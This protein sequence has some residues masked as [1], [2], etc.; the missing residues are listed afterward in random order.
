MA[1]LGQYADFYARMKDSLIG[2]NI[3]KNLAEWMVNNTM[4]KGRKWSFFEHEF[5]LDIAGDPAQEG[6]VKKCSQIG[7]TELAVRMALA[8]LA[9]SDGRSLIYVLPTSKFAAKFSKSR[10]DP[11][12]SSS[13][14]LKELMVTAADSSDLKRIGDSFLYING[15]ADATQAISVPAEGLFT[16]ERDFCNPAVLS[17]YDSRS[18]HARDEKYQ[19]R[20]STP[21]L[22]GYGI[23]EDYSLS[24]QKRYLVKCRHCETWV[25]PDFVRDVVIPGYDNDFMTFDKQDVT[26]AEFHID[27]AYIACH[28]CRRPLDSSLADP[29]RREWVAQYPDRSYVGWWVHPFDLISHNQTAELLKQ[30][31]KYSRMQ[32]Y[33]NFVLG[34]AHTSANARIN[35]EVLR[36]MTSLLEQESGSAT[37]IGIDVGKTCHLLVGRKM[38][39][40]LAILRMIRIRIS[41]ER[42]LFDQIKEVCRQYQAACICIDAGPDFSL[43]RDMKAEFGAKLFPVVYV[44]DQPKI[45]NYFEISTQEKTKDTISAQRTKGFDSLVE[46]FNLGHIS[47]P[48]SAEMEEFKAHLKGMKRIEHE[49][50][51]GNIVAT[52]V[53]DGEDHYFHSLFYLMLACDV[54]NEGINGDVIPAPAAITGI[55]IGGGQQGIKTA[56]QVSDIRQM[57]GRFG[58]R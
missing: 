19:R 36:Q 48:R 38:K 7:L 31:K 18:R 21:T 9:I 24:S 14:K 6:C 39:G 29:S 5:Q 26:N 56:P 4:L 33:M 43:V 46:E 45:P 58:V 20:W 3:F 54:L 13:P 12:I 28:N 41:S 57:M 11:I 34:C 8:W 55:I 15:A 30:R 17:I 32:D 37:C 35:Q 22:D 50:K 1:E 16:D 10:I 2:G 47:L 25:C 27:D 52:W 53:K 51:D 49:D 44:S 23:D 40:Q 42:S